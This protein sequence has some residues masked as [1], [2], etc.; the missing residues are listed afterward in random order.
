MENRAAF[1]KALRTELDRWQA[2]GRV[3]RLWWRDDDATGPHRALDQLFDLSTSFQAPLALAVIPLNVSP[4]DWLRG[5]V[6]VVQH[7]V[8][9]VNHAPR[10]KG[11]GAWELGPHRSPA[12]VL[13]EV[14]DGLARLNDQFGDRLL[15]VMVPPWNRI[16]LA[17]LPGLKEQG[18]LGLSAEGENESR[19]PLPGF[20]RHDGHVD[21]L[22]WKGAAR[23]GGWEKVGGC[24]LERLARIEPD[25]VTGLVTH[26]R[27]MD[28]AAWV[29]VETLLE[30]T[31]D[32]PAARWEHPEILFGGAP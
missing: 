27:E 16:D 23:F 4:G 12:T 24:L 30:I 13:S 21:P 7:G 32:H 3:A 9:H 15:K 14:A 17:L 26:H 5:P 25:Q 31:R 6:T 22:R 11:L 1:A 29:F 18:F 10:G 20:L 19:E 8:A 28:K 2:A